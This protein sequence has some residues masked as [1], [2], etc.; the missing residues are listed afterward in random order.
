M[1]YNNR[2]RQISDSVFELCET[3]RGECAS[4]ADRA[5]LR[6][7]VLRGMFSLLCGRCPRKAKRC[8]LLANARTRVYHMGYACRFMCGDRRFVYAR[9]GTLSEVCGCGV[10]GGVCRV[11]GTRRRAHVSRKETRAARARRVLL[12]PERRG[13]VRRF[14]ALPKN[15][16]GR[17]VFS[18][19]AFT[20]YGVAVPSD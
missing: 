1:Y 8:G 4:A 15:S 3:G 13:G 2:V 20:G 16:R 17:A 12:L 18:G 14:A 6:R 7:G 10:C 11:S 19:G 9:G 5:S